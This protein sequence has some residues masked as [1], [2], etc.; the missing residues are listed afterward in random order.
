LGD[1]V[2]RGCINVREYFNILMRKKT[3]GVLSF[4]DPV[5]ACAQLKNVVKFLSYSPTLPVSNL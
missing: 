5:P 2:M 1:E 4:R 3:F